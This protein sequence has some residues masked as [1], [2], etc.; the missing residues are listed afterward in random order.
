MHCRVLAASGLRWVFCG[1]NTAVV[2]L[3]VMGAGAI[4]G[5]VGVRA[6][7]A[8]V[9]VV[10]VA[11]PDLCE[12]QDELRSVDLDGRTFRPDATIVATNNPAELAGVDL[13]LLTTKS[14]D[15][16]ASGELLKGVLPPGTP[17]ISLQNGLDNPKRLAQVGLTSVVP[18]LVTF[19]VVRDGPVFRQTTSGPI[20]TERGDN[21]A[22]LVELA[23]RMQEVPWVFE[24]DLL[25]MQACKL[26]LNLNNGICAASGVTVAESLRS[27]SLRRA[28][29]LCI[30]EGIKV[31]KVAGQPVQRIGRLSPGMIARLL[32]LPDFLF[33][34]AARQMIKVDPRAKS[35]TLQDLE[36]GRQTEIDDLNGAIVRLGEAHGVQTPANA[37][38]TR[39]IKALEGVAHRQHPSPEVILAGCR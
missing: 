3:G 5:Y 34:Q 11:R 18:G 30:R 24:D 6:A 19:N 32:G 22:G 27:R 14:K 35:S 25:A 16:E 7:A 20:A 8:G 17:V 39:T 10:M 31:F 26:L 38:I 1:T 21:H 23:G 15:T 36:R 12:V 4:G 13:C 33:F 9:S 29:A 2:R 28:F 37:Y